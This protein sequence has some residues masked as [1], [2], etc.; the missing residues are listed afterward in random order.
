M[1]LVYRSAWG[2]AA[3]IFLTAC[4]GQSQVNNFPD[5]RVEQPP[6][7]ILMTPDE[8]GAAIEELQDAAAKNAGG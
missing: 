2:L 3:L 6:T 8:Q 7:P 4:S 1:S 5:L